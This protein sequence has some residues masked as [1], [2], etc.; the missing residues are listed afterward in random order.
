[1]AAAEKVDVSSL[2]KSDFCRA[3]SCCCVD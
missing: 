3:F 1:M 2:K